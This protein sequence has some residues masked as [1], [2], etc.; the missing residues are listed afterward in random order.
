MCGIIGAVGSKSDEF[1]RSNLNLLRKRGPDSQNSLELDF[2]LSLGATRLS[3]T[4]PDP[5]SNQ[6]MLD[7]S[8][9]NVLVFNGEIFNFKSIK[10]DLTEK[11]IVFYTQSD[12]EVLLKALG[13]YGP[14]YIPKLEG[15]FAFAFYRKLTNQLILSRDFLGKKPLYYSINRKSLIFCS[16]INIVQKFI[17]D[18]SIDDSSLLTYLNLGFVLDPK[19]MF[20]STSSVAPGT[21]LSIDLRDIR[22]ESEIRYTPDSISES[23]NISVYESVNEALTQRV[24]GHE[25]FAITLSGGV[26]SSIIALQSVHL[27]L[28]GEAYSMRWPD[29]DKDRY[30]TDFYLANKNCLQLGIKFNPIDMP[31][32]NQIP[33]LLDQYCLAMGEPNSNP[34]GLSMMFLYKLIAEDGHR[35][36][37]TG[38]GAD[39]IFG[40]YERYKQVKKLNKFYKVF[41]R[42]PD[43][44]HEDI[45]R[46]QI[47]NLSVGEKYVGEKLWFRWH[48]NRSN[49]LLKKLIKIEAMATPL[50]KNDLSKFFLK[51]SNLVATTLFNDS[52]IWL[53]MESNRRVDRI[54]MWNSMEA[55]S[56]FQSEKVIGVGYKE[57]NKFKFEKLNKAILVES[58]PKLRSLELSNTKMGFISPLGHWLRN[59]SEFVAESITYL[60]TKLNLNGR[61]L[62]NLLDSPKREN[63]TEFKSLWNLVVLSSWF[64]VNNL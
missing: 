51:K 39:E 38:D 25:K 14:E 13:V 45:G 21:I 49:K 28:K 48:Q 43:L 35:L 55:R 19:T 40:G 33:D 41:D 6:P 53:P 18:W 37:L 1:V 31:S 50:P 60:S 46:S 44:F 5:R 52:T 57:M 23:P 63:F 47:A 24:D 42:F 56:P 2:G 9:G 16:D 61:E 27:G 20:K 10:K 11:G 59:N 7:L 34:T 54:S 12:T 26:D 64:R 15:M 36:L 3:M 17:N 4:D 22:L 62:K 29:S 30:N 58:F 32:A 8:N